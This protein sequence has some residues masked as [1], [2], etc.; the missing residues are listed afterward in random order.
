MV[1]DVVESVDVSATLCTLAGLVPLAT[2]DGMDLSPCLREGAAPGKRV[3][4]TEF[5]WGKSLR[6]GDWRL[7]FYPRDMFPEEYPNG[8]GELYDLADDPWEM[9]NFY[10]DPS[11][12]VTVEEL[13][14][15]LLDWLVASSRPVTVNGVNAGAFGLHRP[16]DPQVTA[17]YRTWACQDGK[18]GPRDIR[19][20]AGGN[21][22]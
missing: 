17:S 13:K 19:A 7:V 1:G 5:A 18:V 14:G 16:D 11:H 3:G 4:V 15:E 21:H 20:R 12:R 6:K 8:F 2:T 10:F 9:R 22:L